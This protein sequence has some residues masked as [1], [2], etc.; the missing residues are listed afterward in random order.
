VGEKK[1]RG[2]GALQARIALP[3]SFHPSSRRGEGNWVIFLLPLSPPFRGRGEP[4]Y[5]DQLYYDPFLYLFQERGG[6]EGA[7]IPPLTF[8]HQE[9]RGGMPEEFF[10]SLFFLGGGKKE[11][12][13]E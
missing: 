13:C 3:H 7:D 6:R 4:P 10:Q 1:G 9:K 2:A 12:N 8:S 5:V 11:N